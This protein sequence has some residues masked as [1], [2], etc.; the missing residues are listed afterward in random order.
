MGEATDVFT[1]YFAFLRDTSK[2]R[3]PSQW[4]IVVSDYTLPKNTLL[5]TT[6]VMNFK[7]CTPHHMLFR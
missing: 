7:I 1:A 5:E 4:Q 3:H 6:D 2:L